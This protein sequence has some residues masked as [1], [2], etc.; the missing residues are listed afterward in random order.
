VCWDILKGTHRTYANSDFFPFV[1]SFSPSQAKKNLQKKESATLP[2]AKT[3]LCVHPN[4][5]HFMIFCLPSRDQQNIT[6]KI[7]VGHSIVSAKL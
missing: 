6:S 7:S 1:G 4:L 3:D 5:D 2:Q